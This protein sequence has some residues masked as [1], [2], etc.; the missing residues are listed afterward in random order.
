MRGVSSRLALRPAIG[1]VAALPF[2]M[3]TPVVAGSFLQ[4]LGSSGVEPLLYMLFLWM[5]RA[6]P[7]AFG[8]LLAF[9]FLHREFT[10]YAVP[11]LVLVELAAG[12]F[13]DAAHAQSEVLRRRPGSRWSGCH[14]R[15]QDALG[16]KV[17][18]PS[19]AAS[20]AVFVFRAGPRCSNGLTYVFTDIWPVLRAGRAMPLGQLRDA[21]FS[22]RRV[23]RRRMD[24][25]RGDAADAR[26]ARLAVARLS[27]RRLRS[28]LPSTSRW[29]GAA[30]LAG[31]SL[32]C[33]Y[34]FPV[35]RYFNLALLLPIGC[36]AAFMAWE[37][38]ARLRRAAIVVFVLWGAANFVD[39]VRVIRDAY[40]NP[41]P[42][43]HRELTEFL[44]SHQIRYA[45]A[46]Y[47]DAYVVDFLS[48]E[49][50][51]VGSCGPVAHSRV[52]RSRRRT[53]RRG[54]D[55]RAHA[56]RRQMR[57]AAWCIQLPVTGPAQGAGDR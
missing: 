4:T 21:Q 32:T 16:R 13:V 7:F 37:P 5:L 51:I 36:F 35:V 47:W 53:P 17:A 40:V 49:R 20:W 2:I 26:Q 38:S 33:S 54:G 48:R 22:G 45:R 31:Y 34:A 25:G 19:G 43:P 8:A 24:S 29:S 11:A 18:D 10:M 6:R 23:G 3:P 50:V 46:D 39:N 1:F 27:A 42:D 30:P 41:Q 12:G 55:H 28:P 57:V 52:R 44:L 15:C 9:G 56:V 14:R